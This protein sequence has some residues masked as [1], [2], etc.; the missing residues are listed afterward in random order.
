MAAIIELSD[1]WHG[2][3]RLE[4]SVWTDNDRAIRLYEGFGFEREGVMR[5]YAW[6]DGVWADALAMARLTD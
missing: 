2:F 5:R 3:R 6:R 1:R 4:L